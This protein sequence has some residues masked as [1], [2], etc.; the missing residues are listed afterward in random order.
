L[1]GLT[2]EV[3]RSDSQS[4]AVWT[5]LDLSKKGY[6]VTRLP[7]CQVARLPGCR[8]VRLLRSLLTVLSVHFSLFTVHFSLFTVHCSLF[9]VHCSLF[10]VHCSLFTVHCLPFTVYRYLVS[11]RNLNSSLSVVRII[12][13]LLSSD[14]S[15]AS[16]ARRK[17]Y[18]SR[19]IAV[20]L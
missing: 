14:F 8:V 10:T 16:I 6:E 9:T 11:F 19:D 1:P 7:G 2:A 5:G 3:M 20:R 17:V 18:R 13:V 12:L 15:S 4:Y